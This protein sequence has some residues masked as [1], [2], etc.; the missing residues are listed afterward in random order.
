MVATFPY[1]EG[2]G[3]VGQEGGVYPTLQNAPI[4][5]Q[6]NKPR[7]IENQNPSLWPANRQQPRQTHHKARKRL[8]SNRP[9]SPPS[10]KQGSPY[11]A[12]LAA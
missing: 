7:V 4:S 9:L 11:Q 3:R 10:R 6:P 12:I 8:R 1:R 2:V 5:E